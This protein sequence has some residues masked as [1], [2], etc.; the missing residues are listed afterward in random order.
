M[1]QVGEGIPGSQGIGGES[2]V[3]F[4]Q[5][6]T[7]VYVDEFQGAWMGLFARYTFTPQHHE[8]SKNRI[9]YDREASM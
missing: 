6:V 8:F 7:S 2:L 9:Y 5:H 1:E 4:E 3:Q